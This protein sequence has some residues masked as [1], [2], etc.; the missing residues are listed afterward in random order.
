MHLRFATKIIDTYVDYPVAL[1]LLA[2]PFIIGVAVDR[3]VS[4]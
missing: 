2:L 3:L 4:V 1:S